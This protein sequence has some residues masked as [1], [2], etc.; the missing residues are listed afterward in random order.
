MPQL[1]RDILE[2][3]ILRHGRFE[4]CDPNRDAVMNEPDAVI[5]SAEHTDEIRTDQ[6]K[7]MWP[8]TTILRIEATSGAACL[9]A[10][11]VAAV[12]LAERSAD[13]LIDALYRAVS[14]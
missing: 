12:S 10:P 5:A 8:G 13:E 11:R 1:L 9:C 2:S 7:V 3:A 6:M 4:L 14:E